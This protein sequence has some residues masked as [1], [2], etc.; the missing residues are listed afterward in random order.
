M[1]KRTKKLLVY[2]D[3]NFISELAK[4]DINNRVK[5]EWKDLYQLLKEGFLDEK[6]VVPQS[7]FHDVETSLAPLLKKRI[8]SYQNYLGQV[9][10]CDAEH[11]RNLQISRFLQRFLGKVDEDPFSPE[12]V[13]RDPPDQRV[14][15]YNI[16]VDLNLAQWQSNSQ[17]KQAAA[18]LEDIRKECVAKSVRYED[19]LDEEFQASRASFL[20]NALYYAYLCKDPAR[21]LVAFSKNPVF[22]T[23]PVVSISSRLWSRVLTK[24][25]TR[26]IKAG[27]ATDIEVLA[28]YLPYMDVIGTDAF[29]ATELS[30]LGIGKE[31]NTRVFSAK[32]KSLQEFCNFLRDHLKSAFPASRP[33]I[34]V[35]VLPSQSVKE[36]AFKLFLDLGAA[37]SQFGVNEYAK[38]YGF[39]DGKMPRYTLRQKPSFKLPFFGLQEVDPIEFKPGTTM[40]GILNICRKHCRSDY[41]VL[42]DE[43]RPI[44]EIF[45]VKAAMEAEAGIQT[46]EGWCI[47]AK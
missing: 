5:K 27:D 3:Q 21:D 47:Y 37:A 15:Q 43:Y 20:R 34:S 45:L 28:T 8:M 29:M 19:Q 1:P 2:L 6:L 31:Y 14:K 30:A 39:D 22:V 36:N 41:F 44:K 26:K 7:L 9:R 32:T 23:I 25:P 10:L 38:I 13:F 40:E 4:A 24:F 35:F 17:R 18:G 16:T 11:V 12:I 33:S 46:T 42:I